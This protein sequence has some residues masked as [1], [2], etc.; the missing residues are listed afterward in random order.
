MAE[1]VSK[2]VPYC[3][4]WGQ[5]EDHM[6]KGGWEHVSPVVLGTLEKTSGGRSTDLSLFW[7]RPAV[8]ARLLGI[9]DSHCGVELAERMPS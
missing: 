3:M 1:R 4:M 7:H 2:S 5:L 8:R 9:Q 6:G